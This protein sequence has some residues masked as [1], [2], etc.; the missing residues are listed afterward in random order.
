MYKSLFA[1]FLCNLF[2]CLQ[3]IA[4]ESKATDKITW[5]TIDWPPFYI[6]D[7]ENKGQGIYDQL[8]SKLASGLPEYKHYRLKMNTI[9]A[10]KLLSAG[11]KICHPS[12]IK[13]TE[14]Q[15]NFQLSLLNSIVLPHRIIIRASKAD[16]LPKGKSL[17]LKALFK[18]NSLRIGVSEDSYTQTIN[19]IVNQNK[20][21]PNVL[22]N[23]NYDVLITLLLNNRL[24]VIIQ[25]P[26]VFSYRARQAAVSD[27]FLTYLIDEEA[28]SSYIPVYIACPKNEWGKKL[29]TKINKILIEESLSP[30]FLHSRLYWY[31]EEEKA[32]LRRFYREFYFIDKTTTK[33]Q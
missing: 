4:Q 5:R 19:H 25:Y 11:K 26:V 8:I 12:T 13:K 31:G 1:L 27:K 22:I 28:A 10:Q 32:I 18:I 33:H 15:E 16:L 17:S 6:L 14:N 20:N 7:A 30:S 3:S 21:Q 24:D 2:V 23:N 9:R 29:I